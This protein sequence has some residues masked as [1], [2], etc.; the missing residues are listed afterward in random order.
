MLEAR[1]RLSCADK[2]LRGGEAPRAVVLTHERVALG[3]RWGQ[4]RVCVFILI[5]ML[6][7]EGERRAWAP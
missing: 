1:K 3:R 7:F 6:Q 2:R 4:E 5:D